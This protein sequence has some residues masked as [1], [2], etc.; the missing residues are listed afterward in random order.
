MDRNKR[1]RVPVGDWA[2]LRQSCV[3]EAM[4]VLRHPED[5][6]EAA[7]EAVLRSWRKLEQCSGAELG[8][9][10]RQISRNEA[11]RIAAR[12]SRRQCEL[13]PEST[14]DRG[15]LDHDLEQVPLKEAVR[16]AL[17]SD[18]TAMRSN[19]LWTHSRLSLGDRGARQSQP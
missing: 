2:V 15:V 4:L 14:P 5:A 9:W 1:S 12:R 10:T 6:E 16:G 8:P 13:S 17:V 18:H 19:S 3:R 11:L 7:Q